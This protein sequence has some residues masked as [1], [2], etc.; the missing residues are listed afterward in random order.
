M[1]PYLE[2]AMARVPASL[3][4]GMKTFFCGPERYTNSWISAQ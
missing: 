4:A 1:T 3:N 2:K